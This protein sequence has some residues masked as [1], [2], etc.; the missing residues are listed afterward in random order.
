MVFR[1]VSTDFQQADSLTKTVK[2]DILAR[3]NRAMGLK[4]GGV[5]A[6]AIIQ[7]ACEGSS[8]GQHAQHSTSAQGGNQMTDD[9]A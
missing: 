8:S 4:V 3:C 1:H 5:S 7:L 9:Q 6:S 2:R